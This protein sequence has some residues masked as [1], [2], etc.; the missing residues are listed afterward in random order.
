M[1][2]LFV[3]SLPPAGTPGRPNEALKILFDT[4]EMSDLWVAVNWRR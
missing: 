2:G 1:G 3:G 4:N